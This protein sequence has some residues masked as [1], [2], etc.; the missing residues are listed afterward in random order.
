MKKEGEGSLLDSHAGCSD[1]RQKTERGSRQ[2]RDSPL[3]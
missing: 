3:A 2:S 1:L